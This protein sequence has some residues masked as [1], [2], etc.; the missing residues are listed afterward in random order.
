MAIIF[1]DDGGD[2]LWD[3]N[4]TNPFDKAIAV[5]DNIE[6]TAM[7]I[8]NRFDVQK[9]SNLAQEQDA[10]D[11]AMK[12]AKFDADTVY[13]D[14][15]MKNANEE[16]IRNDIFR[17]KSRELQNE[18]KLALYAEKNNKR[19]IAEE[20]YDKALEIKA[21]AK[22]RQT[23]GGQIAA[24]GISDEDLKGL[25]Y[26][27]QSTGDTVKGEIYASAMDSRRKQRAND[28]TDGGGV[29]K[30]ELSIAQ[31]EL[32]KDSPDMKVI[33]NSAKAIRTTI[34]E[35]YNK[36]LTGDKKVADTNLFDYAKDLGIDLD[37]KIRVS[38]MT[39]ISHNTNSLYNIKSPSELANALYR[40]AEAKMK[41][42]AKK[43]NRTELNVL[44]RAKLKKIH[45]D[46]NWLTPK[47]LKDP[48]ILAGLAKRFEK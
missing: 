5:A 36:L 21:E 26:T 18:E 8:Q 35:K 40:K 46:L 14:T 11:Y 47:D 13:R 28:I 27:A 1:K 45:T 29:V 32:G 25:L 48:N 23:Y 9:A 16:R 34:P 20:K 37:N 41:K 3:A 30:K 2:L 39:G 17:T 38:Q 4:Q 19:S 6:K 15:M 33:D 12:V 22:V 10:R 24:S 43:D 7:G 31:K 42:K 44:E